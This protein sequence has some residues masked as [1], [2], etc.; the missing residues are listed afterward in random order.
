MQR[1][2]RWIPAAV[3][4][5]ALALGAATALA[6]PADLDPSFSQDGWTRIDSGGDEIARATAIQPDG[7]IVVAGQ[8]TVNG[9]A[10][11]YRL[12]ANGTPDATFDGDG[13]RGLDLGGTEVATAAT[14]QPDGKI[15]VAGFTSVNFDGAVWRLNPNGTLDTTFDGDGVK[16]VD[17]GHVERL[18]AIALQPDGKIV[19]AGSTDVG[20]NAAVYRLNP[21]G[22]F[23]ATFDGDDA[24]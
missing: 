13:A 12:G 21:N 8:T 4:L 22:T 3:G 24:L 20:A 23:D 7:K 11:V 14:I 6:R 18:R 2:R 9:D 17:S 5:A 15:V 16:T 1:T 10:A 19:V